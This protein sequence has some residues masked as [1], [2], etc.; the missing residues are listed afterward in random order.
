MLRDGFWRASLTANV[1][2]GEA[3]QVSSA[4]VVRVFDSDFRVHLEVVAKS[5]AQRA[6]CACFVDE[7]RKEEM[8]GFKEVPSFSGRC[9]IVAKEFPSF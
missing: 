5:C 4:A 2:C 6:F 1:D 8:S 3:G 9:G 7:V